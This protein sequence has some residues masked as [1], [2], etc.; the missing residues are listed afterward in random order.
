MGGEHTVEDNDLL[1]RVME[2]REQVEAT[3]DKGDLAGL[4]HENRQEEQSCVEVLPRPDSLQQVVMFEAPRLV[5]EKWQ[6][7]QALSEAFN[8]GDF[9]EAAVLTKR[10]RYITRIGEAIREKS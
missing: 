4:R 10:L 8:R 7:A 9:A 3:A 1:Q 5:C 2:V 6:W